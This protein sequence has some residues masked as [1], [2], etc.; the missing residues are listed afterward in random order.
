MSA[1]VLSNS[2]HATASTAPSGRVLIAI[3]LGLWFVL[4]FWLGANGTFVTPRGTPPLPILIGV[5]TPITVFIGAF[6][7]SR[8]FRALVLAADLPLIASTHAWRFVG[9]GFLGFY[10]LGI[11]PGYFAWPAALGDMAI[12]LTAPW[13]A[14]ALL[15]RPKFAAS[16][17]FVAWN[18]FGI[19]DFVVAV[20]MGAITPLIFPS[21]APAGPT[22]LAYL[23]LVLIPTYGV[24]MF[25]ILHLTA[26]LQARQQR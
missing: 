13:I 9:F 6:V 12:A 14:R 21:L 19:L 16:K 5:L 10:A 15:E 3:I 2:D 23:P 4:A 20:G 24:P 1:T 7:I 25:I 8:A 18:L 26:L 22:P 17:I 11:L